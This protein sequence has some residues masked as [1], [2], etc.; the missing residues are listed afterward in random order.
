MIARRAAR[1]GPLLSLKAILMGA[2]EIGVGSRP[3]VRREVKEYSRGV[4]ESLDSLPSA[5]MTLRGG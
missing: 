5:R 2:A 3:D 1:M 4:K